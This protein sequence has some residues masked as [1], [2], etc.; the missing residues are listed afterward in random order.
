VGLVVSTSPTFP[1]DV[2]EAAPKANIVPGGYSV[3]VSLNCTVDV[4]DL[5]VNEGDR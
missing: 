5:R 2:E 4:G 1:V 3:S